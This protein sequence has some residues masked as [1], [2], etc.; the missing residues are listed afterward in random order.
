MNMS[1][2][3]DKLQQSDQRAIIILGMHRSGTSC[4]AGSLEEAGVFL[5]P[6]SR[7]NLYNP[8]GSRENR[9]IME[10]Q[11]LVLSDNGG[12]W[13][14]PPVKIHWSE[15]RRM[16]QAQLLEVYCDQKIWGFKDPRTLI[17]LDGWTY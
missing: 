14:S 11:D 8:K 6:V 5:G 7:E 9:A 3:Q 17:L 13:D 4:L 10:L 12:S 1:S 2:Y 15:E 16:I